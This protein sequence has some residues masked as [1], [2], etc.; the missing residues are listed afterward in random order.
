MDM[1]YINGDFRQKM[2][3]VSFETEKGWFIHMQIMQ[4]Y[5]LTKNP[6]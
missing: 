6:T 2:E 4:L 3:T 1:V 5:K